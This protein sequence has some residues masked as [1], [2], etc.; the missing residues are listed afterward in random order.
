M[1]KFTAGG[2]C[3]LFGLINFEGKKRGLWRSK[4]F[5]RYSL[6][7]RKKSLKISRFA[8]LYIFLICILYIWKQSFAEKKVFLKI[9]LCVGGGTHLALLKHF[10]LICLRKIMNL[11]VRSVIL[12]HHTTSLLIIFFEQRF[13]EGV[14]TPRTVSRSQWLPVTKRIWKLLWLNVMIL[15]TAS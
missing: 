6:I 2:G 1:L 4:N 9:F 3:F 8:Y 10:R 13:S 14:P 15:H 11:S 7:N 12:L 5:T